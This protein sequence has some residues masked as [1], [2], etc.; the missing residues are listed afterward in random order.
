M[1]TIITFLSL[2]MAFTLVAQEND[3]RKLSSFN[4]IRVSE[5]IDLV[6]QKGDDNSISI[7]VSR[8]D[9]EDVITEVR[10][11]KL[12]VHLSRGNH[13]SNKVRATLTYTEELK[14][15]EVNTGAQAEFRTEISVSRLSV[16]SSTSGYVR[17]V[18]KAEEV[19]LSA[20][21]S[22]R[23]D[24]DGTTDELEATASTGGTIYAY[25]LT[26]NSAYARANTGADVRINAERRLRASAGTGGSV[27]YTGSPRTDVRS[28]TGGSVRRGG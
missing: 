17:L 24:I 25:D 11:G 26:S 4:E 22:G 9:I 2:A 10:G 12:Y 15:I 16:T 18:A 1:K 7:E 6:A 14:E 8:I 28:N 19:D 20:T 5:G 13:R 3:T 23:I 21:T 27:R